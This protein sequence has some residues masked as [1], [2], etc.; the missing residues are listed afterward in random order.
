MLA[1]RLRRW[2]N[3]T[4]TLVEHP[5]LAGKEAYGGLVF[6]VSVLLEEYERTH[7]IMMFIQTMIYF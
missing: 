5:V 2:P 1:H 6:F 3:I 7:L 4:S